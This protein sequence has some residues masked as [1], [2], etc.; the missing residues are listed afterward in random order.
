MHTRNNTHHH[1]PCYC[2]LSPIGRT[3][4]KSETPQGRRNPHPQKT[5]RKRNNR[6]HQNTTMI[7]QTDETPC[8][9]SLTPV[10]MARSLLPSIV[11][12]PKGKFNRESHVNVV[13]YTKNS[14]GNYNFPS[15][16]LLSLLKNQ[17]SRKVPPQIFYR[18]N[19]IQNHQQN[20]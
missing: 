18:M 16:T 20:G 19:T 11:A 8:G 5:H 4:K 14:E 3:S 6:I 15:S 7:G 17:S 9:P 13:C 10:R 1:K 12:I 2:S